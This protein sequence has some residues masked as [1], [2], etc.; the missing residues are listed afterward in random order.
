[1]KKEQRPQAQIPPC[2]SETSGAV[3]NPETWSS[4]SGPEGQ[5][6]RRGGENQHLGLPERSLGVTVYVQL[7][8]IPA[9]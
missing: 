3:A 7:F 9:D 2:L 4:A 8:S 5:R 1:M 6:H